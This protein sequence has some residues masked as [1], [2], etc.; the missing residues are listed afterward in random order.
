VTTNNED[1]ARYLIERMLGIPDAVQAPEVREEAAVVRAIDGELRWDLQRKFLS[2]AVAALANG[3]FDRA[4]AKLDV[5]EHAL[6][7]AILKDFDTIEKDG[8]VDL[9]NRAADGIAAGLIKFVDKHPYNTADLKL[10]VWASPPV[11]IA[12]QVF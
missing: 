11:D 9:L 8:C 2:G 12:G 6:R 3:A 7:D 10:Y 4:F 5:R 1:A